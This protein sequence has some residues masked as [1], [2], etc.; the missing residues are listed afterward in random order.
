MLGRKHLTQQLLE[1]PMQFLRGR[2]DNRKRGI[3][4]ISMSRRGQDEAHEGSHGR[5][6]VGA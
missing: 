4:G 5:G 2:A 3:L 1:A 6:V